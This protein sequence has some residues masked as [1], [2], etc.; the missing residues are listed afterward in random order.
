MPSNH[1]TLCRP[2][3]LLP[4]ILPASGSFPVSQLFV[5]GA[6]SIG[7]SAST[8]VLPKNIRGWFPLG[9]TGLISLQ[10]KGLSRLFSSTPVQ[11]HQFFWCSV[12][13]MVQLSHL[14]MT[15]GKIITLNTGTFVEKMMPLLFD[16][17]VYV[18]HSFPSKEQEFFNFIAAVSI[19][20]DFG[21]HEKEKEICYCFHLFYFYLPWNQMPWS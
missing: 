8:S 3:L 7:A 10:S 16:Y 2:L 19:H 12:F 18:C 11:K 13:F 6:Q 17:V 5:S 15:T 9:L 14:S 20:S 21:A 4:S 1:L